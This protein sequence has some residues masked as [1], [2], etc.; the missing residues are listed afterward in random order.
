MKTRILTLSI[1]LLSAAITITP[2]ATAG[3]YVGH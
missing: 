3:G 2:L 1:T